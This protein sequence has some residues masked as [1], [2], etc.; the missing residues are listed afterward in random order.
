[1]SV[2]LARGSLWP[3]IRA[4]HASAL[5]AGAL[6][7]IESALEEIE[8]GGIC[9][10]VR[11]AT[12]PAHKRAARAARPPGFDPFLPWDPALFVADVSD[13]YV[14]LLNKFPVLRHHALLTTRVFAEQEEPL[15]PR[16]F[17][18]LWACLAERDALGFYNSSA[19]AGASERHRHLQ[20][21]PPLV[22]GAATCPIDAVLDDARFDG[23]V[24][25]APALPFLH[26]FARLRD[27]AD[28]PLAEAAR[29]L[30][31]LYAEMARAFGCGEPGRPCNLLLTRAWMLF[32]P[33]ARERWE[34]ISINA[35]GFA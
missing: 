24:G 18:A 26:G 12:G 13:A 3:A 34:G 32:V 22:A 16:D 30:A 20:L 31:A 21:V 1:M 11:V 25:H 8:Q 23:P 14:C 19:Q 17:E 7:P 5:A 10:Q 28:L 27:L 4:R 35:L 29:S 6:L 2:A 9:F 15:G 33:R